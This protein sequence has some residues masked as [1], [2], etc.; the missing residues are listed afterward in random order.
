MKILIVHNQYLHPGGEDEVVNA[1]VE[2]LRQFG[3]EVVL[4]EKN[5]SEI[6]KFSVFKKVTFVLGNVRFSKDVY[7]ELLKFIK[8]QKPDIAHFHNIYLR[9][10]PAAYDA[11][12]DSKVPIV[13]TLHNYRPICPSGT[14]FR[15][16]IICEDCLEKGNKSVVINRCWRNSYLQ[17]YV[18]VNALNSA[19]KNDVYSKKIDMF[20]ALSKFSKEKMVQNGY[21][22]NR[23][24]IKPNFLE[25]S[26]VNIDKK[27]EYILFIGALREYKGILTLM[28][29]WEKNKNRIKLKIVGSG[30]LETTLEKKY[31][32]KNLEFLGQQTLKDTIKYIQQSRFVVVPSEC[33]ETFS[34]VTME[35]YSCGKPVLASRLGALQ[36]I[37]IDGKT[38]L[39]FEPGNVGDL[40]E[41]INYLNNRVDLIKEFGINSRKIFEEKYTVTTNYNSL[42]KIYKTVL[43]KF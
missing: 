8:I 34:R 13:Q 35:A 11:C 22:K 3:H 37:V 7:T 12:V 15:N 43:S 40:A 42:I 26:L 9:V 38:G 14:F 20:I 33:Y 31:S 18:L 6:Q 30:P 2:M 19:L 10:T 24:V 5:N 28:E 41:K 1:E 25:S 16:N 36:D 23:I 17:S 27:G 32:H 39:F 21:D 29:A 4:F